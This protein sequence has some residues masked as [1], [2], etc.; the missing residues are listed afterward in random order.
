[1]ILGCMFGL[2]LDEIVFGIV[3]KMVVGG[4]VGLLFEGCYGDLIDNLE[5]FTVG[6]L[7]NMIRRSIWD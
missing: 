4:L 6:I 1:M 5:A 2:V 7:G 3:M